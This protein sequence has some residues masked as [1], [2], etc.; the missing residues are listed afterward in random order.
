MEAYVCIQR[1]LAWML[2]E[3]YYPLRTQK[4]APRMFKE[5]YPFKLPTW[6]SHLLESIIMA[7]VCFRSMKSRLSIW[8]PAFVYIQDASMCPDANVLWFVVFDM[9][10]SF[11][12]CHVIV[13]TMTH[14]S[15]NQTRAR[16]DHLPLLLFINPENTKQFWVLTLYVHGMII[17]LVLLTHPGNRKGVIFPSRGR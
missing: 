2:H 5:L 17:W 12:R 8:Q 16:Y 3:N 4:C 15:G 10:Y 11:R 13:G 9:P 6:L 14:T 1:E 7:G